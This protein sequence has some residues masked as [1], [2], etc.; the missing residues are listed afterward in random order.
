MKAAGFN[1][2]RVGE[3]AWCNFEPEEGRFEFDWLDDAIE[4][5]YRNGIR[6]I[7][8]TPT[9]TIPAWMAAKYPHVMATHDY[10]SRRRF[11]LRKDYCVLQPDF[12]RLALRVVEKIARHYAR[13]KR[14]IGFQTD[15]EFASS[16]CRCRCCLG[17]FQEFL[18]ERYGTIARLNREYGTWFWGAVY[19]RF[20]EIDWPASD[21]PNPSHGLDLKRFASRVDVEH[22]AAQVRLLRQLAPG[23][24][25]THNL[26]GLFPDMDYYGLSRDLDF[27]SWDSYPGS[28]TGD[29]F[30]E[31]ALA[32][33]VMWSMKQANFMIMEKQS[34]P[35]GWTAYAPATAPGEQ[36]MLA[37]QSI[38]RGADAIS[39]FRWRTSISGQEQ[40][41]HGIINHD[42][43][44]RRRYREV[45]AMGKDVA[46][47]SKVILGTEPVREVGIY[48]SYE[49]IWA[50]DHQV[51]NGDDPVRFQNI[52]REVSEALVL[53]GVDTGS[54]GDG[55][56][57]NGYKAVVCPPLYLTHP[58]LVAALTAY[59]KRGGHLVLTARSGVK[60]MNNKNLMQPLPGP[61]AALAGVEVEEY[62]VL[63]KGVDWGVELPQ[64][65]MQAR[66]IRE[67]LLV[68]AGT[69]VAGV[70]RGDYMDGLPAIT[71]RAVGKGVV[72]YVGTLPSAA[73][74]RLLFQ[75]ILPAAKVD[76]RADLNA[77]VEIAHRSGSGRQLTFV[78][79]HTGQQQRV[80][81]AGTAKDLLGG[82]TCAGSADLAP[83]GVA[84]LNKRA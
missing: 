50:T 52:M 78:L 4:G 28:M 64:G 62:A 69:Q 60:T 83:Y 58:D 42:N 24:F 38:A 84:I 77:G 12:D 15:N 76:F 9:A 31:E 3:F 66:R 30:A 17:H 68:K 46:R 19:N 53:L 14:I 34:G 16:R 57:L 26:M 11:G 21:F 8:G 82:R 22:Q 36:S 37:W 45:A 79:N 25:I 10:V 18:R 35:G 20:D 81:L 41:W 61:L 51:Q 29:R 33:T 5:L 59:V 6:T 71:R 1:V 13:D 39:Y 49:Q 2:V 43:V 65:R 63:P 48:N 32:H 55:Q 27:I 40:Y 72:W 80:R 56:T 47:L 44:P 75:Q 67:H 54:F 74:W 73:D 7:I 70:H 23:K